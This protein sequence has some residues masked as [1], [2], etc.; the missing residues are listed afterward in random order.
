MQGGKKENL[1]VYLLFN[2]ESEQSSSWSSD[3]AVKDF[4][5]APCSESLELLKLTPN[6]QG[7][8]EKSRNIVAHFQICSTGGM[9]PPPPQNL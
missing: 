1:P 2:S 7:S 4:L 8:P 3:M 6:F 5:S 9:V